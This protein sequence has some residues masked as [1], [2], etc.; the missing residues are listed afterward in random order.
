MSEK[1]KPIS[2]K[3][4]M[5]IRVEKVIPNAVFTAFNDLIAEKWNGVSSS[6]KKKEVLKRI[7]GYMSEADWDE[8]SSTWAEKHLLDIEPFYREAGWQVNYESPD[9]GDSNFEEY[10]SFKQK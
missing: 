10:F 3:Q 5:D 2:P 8:F 6:V 9:R 7:S 4:V 1:I